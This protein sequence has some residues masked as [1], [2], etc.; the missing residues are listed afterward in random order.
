MS[1]VFLLIQ[2]HRK[3][4]DSEILEKVIVVFDV[5]YVWLE[6]EDEVL[7]YKDL[8][9]KNTVIIVSKI[10]KGGKKRQT[11]LILYPEFVTCLSTPLKV[12]L[13]GGH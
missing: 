1:I 8:R 6:D 11:H 13:S 4:Q 12:Q 5:L 3:F 10:R 7:S 2:Q 9:M